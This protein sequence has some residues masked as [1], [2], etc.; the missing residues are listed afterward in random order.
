MS[1][2]VADIK[3]VVA[4]QL[5]KDLTATEDDSSVEIWVLRALRHM[6]R[7]DF[8]CWREEFRLALTAGTYEYP[9][10]ST[11]WGAS[12]SEAALVRPLRID[13][14]SVRYSGTN[15][16]WR[17][18]MYDMDIALGSPRWKDG[19]N[20]GTPLYVTEKSQ[21]LIIGAPPDQ[22]FVDSNPAMQGYY[23]R[24]EDLKTSGFEDVALAMYDDFF[25][26][27]VNLSN[28]F[29]MQ[30]EDDTE[31]RA[32]LQFWN[33]NDLVEMRSYDHAPRSDE[34]IQMPSWGLYVEGEWEV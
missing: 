34:P 5:H 25:E 30:Q 10:T 28:V 17:E 29:G 15:L 20:N 23:F 26:H 19:N 9:Y 16:I 31:F 4:S 11:V 21:G 7:H 32:M 12:G 24:G 33:Q 3:T 2:T 1:V 27:A 18:S 13:G 22:N 14:N 8:E 6:Q